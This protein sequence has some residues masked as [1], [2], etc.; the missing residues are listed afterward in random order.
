MVDEIQETCFEFHRCKY[1]P[2]QRYIQVLYSNVTLNNGSLNSICMLTEPNVHVLHE[3][4][5][6]PNISTV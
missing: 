1:I 4:Y 3:D 6:R 5:Q 2:G